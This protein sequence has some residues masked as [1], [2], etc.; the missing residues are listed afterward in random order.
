MCHAPLPR[1]CTHAARSARDAQEQHAQRGAR[2]EDEQRVEAPA[3]GVGQ[4][5]GV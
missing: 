2:R 3:G 5:R 4:Q 1:K